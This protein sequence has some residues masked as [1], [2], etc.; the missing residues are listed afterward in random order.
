MAMKLGPVV[1]I[2][3]LP[4]PPARAAELPANFPEPFGKLYGKYAACV[5]RI[6]GKCSGKWPVLWVIKTRFPA[7]WKVRL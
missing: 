3:P 5:R 4:C 1:L 2:R 6:S 7:F